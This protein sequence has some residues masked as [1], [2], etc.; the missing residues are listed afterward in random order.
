MPRAGLTA[1][2]VVDAAAALADEIG[3]DRVTVSALARGFG[4]KDAS[5]YAHIKNL[6]DLRERLALTC[7]A[8]F[9]DRLGAG[10]AGRSGRDALAGF[11][12]AYRDYAAQ[13]P[14]RYA[15]TQLQLPDEVTAGSP[16]HRRVIDYTYAV[17]RAYDLT[18][19]DLTDAVRLVRSTLY[20]FTA[21]EADAAF[22]APRDRDASWGRI[23]AALHTLLSQWPR[24][25]DE[26]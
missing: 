19:P 20:G 16:A 9:A 1:D 13:H 2:R 11:A 23:L 4:V 5:L 21:L 14:G 10:I 24:R 18:E 6:A 7:T 15:A 3:L 12:D 17:F 22:R 25:P 26:A 8:E